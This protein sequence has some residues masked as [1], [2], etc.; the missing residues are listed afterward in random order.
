ME[1]K[2]R[3]MVNKNF[4]RVYRLAARSGGIKVEINN[5]KYRSSSRDNRI[6]NQLRT[7]RL[8]D[9]RVIGRAILPA[10]GSSGMHPWCAEHSLL[11]NMIG[12][13]HPLEDENQWEENNLKRNVTSIEGKRR[14]RRT[15]TR[16]RSCTRS[17]SW[18]LT[19][20]V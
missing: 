9:E 2:S 4:K 5:F 14:A 10:D 13:I 12:V 17:V 20:A 16:P 3:N 8:D 18:H 19:D 7:L 15:F 1:N 11:E 6:A